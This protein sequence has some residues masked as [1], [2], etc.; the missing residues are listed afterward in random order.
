[1]TDASNKTDDQSSEGLVRDSFSDASGEYELDKTQNYINS[2]KITIQDNITSG[3]T[4]YQ[5]SKTP[6]GIYVLAGVEFILSLVNVATTY[7]VLSF[8]VGICSI[9][10]IILLVL[11]VNFARI[12]FIAYGIFGIIVALIILLLLIPLQT[13]AE[14]DYYLKNSNSYQKCITISPQFPCDP[15]SDRYITEVHNATIKKIQA[16]KFNA[17]STLIFNIPITAYLMSRRVRES[18]KA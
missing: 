7:S 3:R 17:I 2:Q 9:I 6:V 14:N 5:K 15:G 1:M 10:L 11:Q 8:V 18:F 4:E 12:I 13:R 16:E